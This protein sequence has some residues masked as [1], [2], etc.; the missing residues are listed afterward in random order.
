[1]PFKVFLRRRRKFLT[2]CF[3]LSVETTI[4]L[5]LV[6][7]LKSRVSDETAAMGDFGQRERG[8]EDSYV[9]EDDDDDDDV[10][11]RSLYRSGTMKCLTFESQREI[12]IEQN[13]TVKITAKRHHD[14]DNPTE[15]TVSQGNNFCQCSSLLEIKCR[16]GLVDF[17]RFGDKIIS[18]VVSNR[19]RTADGEDEKEVDINGNLTIYRVYNVAR[20]SISVLGPNAF[21]ALRLQS[22]VANYNPIGDA[23]SEH[24]FVG[25]RNFLKELQL[26]ACNLRFL[27]DKLL[28]GLV[29]LER[30]HLWNNRI[31]K[32]PAGFFKEA[33][34]LK[35]LVL[36]GNEIEELEESTLIGLWN[37]KRLDLDRN[38]IR[39][40]SSLAFRHL[41]ELEV[42]QLGD[43]RITTLHGKTF[44]FMSRL[45]VLS[46][47]RNSIIH[48]YSEAFNNLPHLLILSLNHNQI[49][50]LPPNVFT[51]LQNLTRLWLSN[52]SVKIN[53]FN[54]FSGLKSLHELRL[55]DNELKV[56]P[57]GLF[58]NLN[59]L[60]HLILD[61]NELKTLVKCL[62]PRKF[63]LKNLSLVGNPLKCGCETAWLANHCYTLS[64]QAHTM[65][66]LSS[67]GDANRHLPQ[68]RHQVHHQ[69]AT[70]VWGTCQGGRDQNVD[71]NGHG[72]S[73]LCWFHDRICDS[74]SETRCQ[75]DWKLWP[76]GQ[77]TSSRQ[78]RCNVPTT[79]TTST[80]TTTTR[81]NV[82]PRISTLGIHKW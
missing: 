54:M 46:L 23:V 56:L 79:S 14:G 26:G 77:Q 41:I 60:R 31:S 55:A 43:N 52:N 68:G 17:P 9:S 50:F 53:W 45:K 75:Q 73:N 69:S 57:E 61:N 58:R 25:L 76:R 62:F 72:I 10:Y 30:I 70:F 11:P 44:S 20:Q 63:R 67:S 4:I 18:K 3:D 7:G 65:Q 64:L 74:E 66:S 37:L 6:V 13:Y 80:T 32:I 22:V 5:L 28:A 40:L 78:V 19:R 51:S 48:L 21:L 38:K 59:R 82:S 47:N 71:T 33:E 27:P 34:E 81:A 12:S 49:G 15:A 8:G 29:R 1:M 35:E 16:G 36:W 42:L 39:N 2:N 24:A